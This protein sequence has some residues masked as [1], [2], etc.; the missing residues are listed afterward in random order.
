MQGILNILG[1]YAYTFIHT[2]TY[3]LGG[4]DGSIFV[5]AIYQAI[6]Q[7]FSMTSGDV[8]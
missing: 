8:N 3:E 1:F 5:A 7:R 6:R 4:S 2:C